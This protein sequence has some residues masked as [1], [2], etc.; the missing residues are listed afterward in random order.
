MPLPTSQAIGLA[1][2]FGALGCVPLIICVAAFIQYRRDSALRRSSIN[3]WSQAIPLE[4]PSSVVPARH[5]PDLTPS[6]GEGAI[7][8]ITHDAIVDPLPH[9]PPPA[10]IVDTGYHASPDRR[11]TSDGRLSHDSLFFKVSPSVPTM[12]RLDQSDN[13]DDA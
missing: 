13:V 3:A 10:W 1:V 12:W 2:G 8:G 11:S 5:S 9:I 6:I 4:H 7:T